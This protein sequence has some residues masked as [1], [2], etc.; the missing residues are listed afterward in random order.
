MT[1]PVT[2]TVRQRRPAPPVPKTVATVAFGTVVGVA[3]G[4]DAGIVAV[5]LGAV[6]EGNVAVAVGSGTS[7]G[8]VVDVGTVVSIGTVDVAAAFGSSVMVGSG[9]VWARAGVHDKTL[10]ISMSAVSQ[11][12]KGRRWRSRSERYMMLPPET[13]A[14]P[15][16][17]A[18]A[19]P[20]PRPAK[21]R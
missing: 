19:I 1:V 17:G 14:H 18:I 11:E 2:A 7:V 21:R 12:R 16:G 3:V 10:V 6:V 13:V 8:T 9:G 5:G 4:D 20:P 15:T